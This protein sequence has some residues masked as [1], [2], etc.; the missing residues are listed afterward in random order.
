MLCIPLLVFLS[1]FLWPLYCLSFDLR[2]LVIPLVSSGHCIVC[3]SST[4]GS[5]LS[6]WYLVAIVLSVLLRLTAPGYPFGILWPL[7]CLSSFDLRLLVIPLV[8]C[9]HCIVCPP[10]TYGSW[11]SLWYLV[12]IVLSVL[13]LTAPGY[14]FGILW[15]LHCLSFF[16]LQ[17]LV[18]PLV[19]CGHCIV[20]PPST[21]GSWL[22]LWYLVAIALSV[23]RH[24][25]PG[26]PFGILWPLYC[27]SSFDL[28]L[29]VIPLISCGHCIVCPS[30]TYGSW[31]SLWYLVVIALS[32]L[33][34]MAPGY[35]FGILW[36]LY[37][38]SF[39]LRLLFIPL[40]SC[41]HCIVCPPSTYGSWLS[42][43]YLVAI[44]L[45]V[46]RI[47]APGY[48]FG[49]LW[50]LY[51]LSFDLRLLVILWYHVAIVLSVLLTAP[52]Y[53]FGILWPLYC[54]SSFD[55]RLLVIPLVSCGHCIVCP[56][57]TYRS[58]LS[59]WY[60]VAIV[61]SVL[62]LTLLVIPLVSCGHC[63]VCPS[64]TYG[65]W[66][67]LW[68]LVA[69]VLSV[70]LRLTAPGYPFDILWPLYC[71]S[72]FDL[73]LLVIPLVSCGHCIVCPSTYGSWL[74]LWYLMAIVLSV[75]R[76]T[77]PVYPFGILWPLYCLSSFDL[78]LLVI[79]LVSCGHCIVCPSNY[80]SWLSLW[81]L[82][83]I[84]L[85]VLRHTTPGYPFGILWPL[86]CLSS[87]DLRL[88]VIPLISCG[89]CIVCPSSTYGSWLS[90]WYLVAIALSVLRLMAP[91][92]PFGILWP[93]YCLSFDLRLLFI[94]LVSCG[95]CIVS[96]PSTY[97][98]WLSLWYL[99]AIVLSVLRITAPGYPFGILWPLYCLSFD[100][101][102]LVILWYHVAIVLSVLL[103]APG[104]PFGILW[105]LYCLSFF[106]LRLLVI[107]LVSCGHCIVC[108]P[109][110]YGSWLSLWYI[111]AIVLSVLLR[112]TAPG[113]SFGIVWPLYC[114]SFDLRLL[115]IPLVSCGHCIVCPPSTYG[116]WLSL[117]YLVAIVLSVLLRLT[118]PGYPFGILW[119]LYCLS[120]DLR[121]LVI[122]LV[123]CGHCIVCPST[124]GSWLSLWYFVAIVLS[125][126]LRLTAPGYPLIS[127]GHCIV[128]PST[129]GSFGI[130]WPLY[131]LSFDLR[132]L[133]IPLVS[134]GHCIVC[135]S[136]YGSF[137]ILWPLY[138]LSFD[139]WLLVIPLVSCGHCIVCPPSTYGSW[140]SLWY[141]VAIVLSVL[142]LTAPGYPFGILWPL[143]CLS[144]D[145]QLLV[146]P[147]VSCG[148]CIVCPPSTY[149]SWLSLWYLVAIV[150]S[151]LLRLTL[152]VISLVS[153]GHCIV[154]PWTY[155]SWL[156]LWYLVAIVLSVLLRL[157]SPGYPFGILWPLYCLSSFDLRLL[158][159]P[160]VS[161]GHCIF[162]PS[163]YDSWLSLWYL[164]AIVL[165]VLLRL[166]APG[167]PFDILWPLYCLSFFD[168][169]L[170]VIPLV[171]CGHC[172]ICPSTY[173]SWLSLWYL[174]A[175]VLSVLLRLTAPGYP[176]GILWPLYCLSFDLR[177]LVITLVSCGHCIVYPSTYAP[178][179]PFGI[180]W[181]LY[182]LSF[183]LRLLVIPLVSC[184]HCIV[185]PSTY[186][187]WLSLWYH[188]AIVLSVL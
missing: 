150:L 17:L 185:C 31:L 153:C 65:S 183:E 167:Y 26:Y 67:S 27:L 24:T 98:S 103:T 92:Y 44:V 151:V 19:S 72:F 177:L 127:C 144:F 168:L 105:P 164:V 147:L 3:P 123:S 47:T 116:S 125:V 148:H 75:L 16:D 22:S 155:G 165:S 5:W 182:C 58:W 140:L 186:G 79:P 66:L 142:R 135:P 46:L 62:R 173:G 158:F 23:L 77:A 138:Y 84:A 50:P 149:G 69:I 15:P 118:A 113:Y 12:A 71:L 181:P 83:A 90:L 49:I 21:Y 68:Y 85:S 133:V 111:V 57:S 74:S 29:L 141:I 76:L 59:L 160:L 4:Y 25:T 115:V 28:R 152:L 53:P 107:P 6:L 89:H 97:G 171:S 174:V 146:I 95:H 14:P 63:I 121:L 51:C 157:T 48:P 34:L 126:L 163:T 124:Y 42:L 161:C 112:L 159:I 80:G 18:I 93:L 184:G 178:G 120:F 119:P 96:P 114:L 188:V 94:P 52:G 37:C 128:C 170:L 187:S 45:S 2:F 129:Y 36:P 73:W 106:D 55:L 86:Y 122:P 82:V 99:V 39:D 139:L 137:G 169:W 100:L 13:R 154:C 131:Y 10:S 32:V 162:C 56:P 176:F 11:L 81:Y 91:G 109:S 8:S 87:F 156:S 166:T 60:L 38:L 88:L 101:R 54:L 35:P 43:W 175:I 179:Y 61:L 78:R 130:L 136:T 143:Y 134:C 117:W 132:L 1:C 108:P 33:R 41:G 70:L 110:T 64:S 180:L 102:L 40:V 20:C 104:Y 30:S 145:L 9:G 7:Y 172:I